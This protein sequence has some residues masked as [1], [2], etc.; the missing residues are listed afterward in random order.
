MAS[1][2]TFLDSHWTIRTKI[3]QLGRLMVP[4]ATTSV[5][6]DDEDAISVT[7][8]APGQVAT[9][10]QASQ[11]PHDS[12]S[13]RAASG[14]RRVDDAILSIVERMNVTTA[15]QDHLLT[16]E[17]EA[18]RLHIAFCQWMGLEVAKLEPYGMTLWTRR[19]PW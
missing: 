1:N 6:N 15:V 4:A 17:Q 5:V 12:R 18:S 8:Q 13:P 19:M 16:A 11:P 3:S 7:S 9:S 14:F 10:T 2:L